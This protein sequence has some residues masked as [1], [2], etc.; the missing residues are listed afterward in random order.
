MARFT[1]LTNTES[2]IMSRTTPNRVA[3]RSPR[4]K[5]GHAGW[6]ALLLALPLCLPHESRAEHGSTLVTTGHVIGFDRRTVTLECRG[7]QVRVDRT[8]LL[9]EAALKPGSL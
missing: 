5:L 2:N 8:D 7:R 3:R 6:I 1:R 9:D 4:S